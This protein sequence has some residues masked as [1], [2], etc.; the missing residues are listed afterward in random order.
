MG[1]CSMTIAHLVVVVWVTSSFQTTYLFRC[2]LV[3]SPTSPKF[4][5]SLPWG[6]KETFP[7]NCIA[8]LALEDNLRVETEHAPGQVGLVEDRLLWPSILR[9]PQAGRAGRRAYER[10]GFGRRAAWRA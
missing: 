7:S 1:C 8:I 3:A 2:V 5:T 6:L 4:N 9:P 10:A